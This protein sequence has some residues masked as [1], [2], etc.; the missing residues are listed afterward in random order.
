[1]EYLMSSIAIT[2][3]STVNHRPDASLD[4][5]YSFQPIWN[6]ILS[7]LPAEVT[8]RYGVAAPSLRPESKVSFAAA[9]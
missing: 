7:I 5:L 4:A 8:Q 2:V 6:P 3:T 1:M 9:R